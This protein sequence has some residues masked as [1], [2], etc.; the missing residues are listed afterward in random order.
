[1]GNSLASVPG[2]HQGSGWHGTW[3]G[4][5]SLTRQELAEAAGGECKPDRMEAEIS[6]PGTHRCRGLYVEEEVA[7]AAP[8]SVCHLIMTCCFCVRQG[9]PL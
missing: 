7:V 9:V 5:I 2:S 8:F 3:L 6:K 4:H 1:M